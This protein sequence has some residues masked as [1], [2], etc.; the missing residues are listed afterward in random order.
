VSDTVTAA[1]SFRLF[2]FPVHVRGGFMFFLLLVFVVNSSV[3]VYGIWLAVFLTSFTLLHELGH[4]FAARATGAHAEI[5]L[6]FLYG[7][8]AFAPTRPLKRWER[9]AISFAGPGIQLL[10]SGLLLLAMG[11]NPLDAASVADGSLA[12]K[13]LW[14]AGPTIALINLIPVLPFDGGNIALMG[15]DRLLPTG[16]ARP[17]MLA[18]SIAITV[19]GVLC[20][21]M[22]ASQEWQSLA[23]FAA[24]PLI[25]QI[26]MANGL[27]AERRRFEQ[28]RQRAARAADERRLWAADGGSPGSSE[29]GWSPWLQAHVLR[30]AGMTDNARRTLIRSLTEPTA[31]TWL[32]PD[33]AAE[34]QLEPLVALLPNPAPYG[35]AHGELVLA[36]VLARLGEYEQ[37]A[38]Y[39]AARYN[40]RRDPL[41]AVQVARAAAALGDDATA[42]AWLQ[43]ALAVDADSRELRSAISAASELE[44]LRGEQR[45]R[46]MVS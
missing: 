5:A 25:S 18:A 17:V 12:A 40:E 3:P 22:Y 31:D 11:V 1:A 39:A 8:A 32:P 20:L 7:Y 43:A 41:L 2:G 29:N 9:A 34:A 33:G 37:L 45:F 28:T 38:A 15:L 30:R 6:D 27:S 23:I 13:A 16:K 35:N 21:L 24:L 36:D 14:F 26:Q 42:F 10:V 4:A 46:T 44:A 19:T